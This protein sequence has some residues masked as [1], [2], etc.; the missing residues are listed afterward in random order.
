MY[1]IIDLDIDDN[2]SADT[3]V[4]A[5]ALVEFPAIETNFLYFNKEQFQE[6]TFRVTN[7]ISKNACRARKYK[8]ENPLTVCGTN[9]GW[10][11]SAQLC[12]QRPISLDTVKRMFSYL[13]RHKIDLVTSKSYE[14]SCG[15]LMYDAWGG[16]EAL[17][18]SKRILQREKDFDIDVNN[19]PEY[20]NYPTGDTKDN[21]LV[22][23]IAFIE[24]VPYERKEDYISRCI[25]WHIKNKGWDRD[26]A[27]AVCYNQAEEDF[28]CGCFAEV[29]ERGGIKESKKAPKSDTPNKN[30]K[31]EGTAKG[32]AKTTRGAEVSERVE[33]ILKDKSDDFNERY[34][35]K[36]GYGVNVG[37]LKSVYQRGVG[38]YNTSHSPAVK[39]AEQW[40]LARVNA[41]LYLVRNGR[42]ENSKYVN[43]NDLLPE[44]H[45]KSGKEKM[46]AFEDKMTV[47]VFGYIT[48]HF[49]MCP[50][51]VNTFN[52]LT[53][54][55]VDEDTKGM[56][57]SAAQIA[58]NVFEIEKEVIESQ[59]A[60]TEQL[61]QANILVDDFY[62]LIDEIDKIT[63]M[64]H[65]VD[66]MDGHI[67]LISSYLDGNREMFYT[68]E[69]L[70]AQRHLNY[71]KGIDYEAFQAVVG[72]MRGRSGS[73][74]TAMNHKRPTIYFRYDRKVV[75]GPPDRD[76][77]MSIEGRYFRR[78]E[79]DALR[80]INTDFGHNG[81]PYSKWLWHGGPQCVHA[82][83][84]FLVQEAVIA[85]QGWADGRAGMAPQELPGKGYYPGTP[86][87]EA[88]LSSVC[89]ENCEISTEEQ[90]EYK[91]AKFKSDEE[92]RMLYSPLMVPGILIPRVENGEKYFVRFTKKAIEKIQRKFMIEQRLRDT[93]LEHDSKQ[94][95]KDMVMVESWL[96][97]GTSDK[98]F[99]LGYKPKEIP[100]G[101][102][103]VG[104]KV[105]DTPEGNVIWND[106]IKTG[107]VKGLSAEGAFLMNF[108][109]INTSEYLLEE[110]INILNQIN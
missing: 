56:I 37:M 25:E 5:V 35:E 67:D 55:E 14:G 23:P 97:N 26:Q 66:Y 9:I 72:N 34:K 36:L 46:A 63:G 12:Q 52:H 42:P 31:G 94:S 108:Q 75:G 43:D 32:D 81:Q 45:P 47:D 101:T 84:K 22:E 27:A 51:A 24:K 79:I 16:E 104:Y 102:W 40:A 106:F 71:L 53:S 95:F 110:I 33:K 30:P 28:G 48:K 11:R 44:K 85:D 99:T 73:E 57:R 93:N 109:Q 62:D 1:K 92:Q 105:L 80:D 100:E 68:D 49:D 7:E 61:T 39:S 50:G 76:F 87:Y 89:T 74:V 103:M 88:N 91:K 18:W 15:L 58:D 86:R 82:W 13:S 41:F 10:T 38:A 2:L 4:D 21:M 3:K 65:D 64:E 90:I 59:R 70:E 8:Q 29:G 77:C 107:K 98:A 69:D 60:T 17:L 83:R 19:L 78:L 54:M 6:P 96:V 20:V